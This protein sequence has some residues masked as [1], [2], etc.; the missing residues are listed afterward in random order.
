M[1]AVRPSAVHHHAER[2]PPR[3]MPWCWR[4]LSCVGI[5]QEGLKRDVLGAG[6]H[7]DHLAW[8]LGAASA[9][10]RRGL[11]TGVFHWLHSQ[12]L[13]MEEERVQRW[14]VSGHAPSPPEPA[15]SVL[16]VP[17]LGCP[18]A[19]T[20]PPRGCASEGLGHPAHWLRMSHRFP[21]ISR[22]APWPWSSG[23]GSRMRVLR[24][25]EG[26]G[27]TRDPFPARTPEPA[28]TTRRSSR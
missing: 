2:S 24:G 17:T 26:G 15:L 6:G 8:P 11:C 28:L 12:P 1:P 14:R 18:V 25:Q 21:E 5:L 19:V 27:L 10:S 13:A 20:S 7:R 9:G 23:E 4:V 22:W 16:E 3:R